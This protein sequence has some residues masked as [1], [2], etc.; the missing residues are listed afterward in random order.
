MR[1]GELF[2]CVQPI[3]CYPNSLFDDGTDH[4]TRIAPGQVVVFLGH[5]PETATEYRSYV[6]LS[7]VSICNFITGSA[8]GALHEHFFRF[9]KSLEETI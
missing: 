3:V 7:G 5:R 1:Q 4:S 9:F 8:L 6:I 2:K